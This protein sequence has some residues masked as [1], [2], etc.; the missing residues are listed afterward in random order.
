MLPSDL[1]LLS[2]CLGSLEINNVIIAATATN[3]YAANRVSLKVSSEIV[4]G[5]KVTFL[6]T[7]LLTQNTTKPT[8][9]FT[10]N[11]Y[12]GNANAIDISTNQ[13]GLTVSRMLV[14]ATT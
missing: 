8:S 2:V 6:L 7:N 11:T 9:T 10:V 4:S 3:N 12:D 14:G 1:Q 13:M 5:S